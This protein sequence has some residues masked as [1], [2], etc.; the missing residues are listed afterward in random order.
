MG[1]EYSGIFSQQ[2]RRDILKTLAAVPVV[3]GLYSFDADASTVDSSDYPY[4]GQYG[5]NHLNQAYADSDDS[6]TDVDSVRSV[7]EDV[8]IDR[9]PVVGP[10]GN[11]AAAGEF[12]IIVAGN[13]DS[14][15][16]DA[17]GIVSTPLIHD[18]KVYYGDQLSDNIIDVESGEIIES[19]EGSN[20]VFRTVS[21]SGEFF[22]EKYKGL[23]KFDPDNLDTINSID[24]VSNPR[25]YGFIPRDDDFIAVFE[26]GVGK[27]DYEGDRLAGRA[28][29]SYNTNISGTDDVVVAIRN[30]DDILE[31]LDPETDDMAE[32]ASLENSVFTQFEAPCAI[33]GNS[34]Y[35]VN[36]DG[37]A[38][39]T[40]Y[41]DTE[42]EL[43]FDWKT[44]LDGD[45]RNTVVWGEVAIVS[46]TE[47]VVGLDTESGDEI[48]STSDANGFVSMPHDT[49][50]Y[51]G[52][53][54]TLYELTAELGDRAANSGLNEY[55]NDG[56]V[57]TSQ[58]LAGI[59]DWR[60]GALD[61]PK[62]LALINY[63]RSGET[64][65]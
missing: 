47:Q 11:V 5:G 63:W 44:E 62:L 10:N 21:S 41:D 35:N 32:K 60:S 8:D 53:E 37:V 38:F 24:I 3:G 16:L 30:G 43:K 54:N 22:R 40:S 19:N 48:W 46:T 17:D 36:R 6:P 20:R 15:V 31:V 23:E 55:T 25:P 61:T 13:G 7:E 18:G 64:I 9:I 57:G 26:Q 14:E 56:T 52:G 65:K 51:V 2:N 4:P 34:F 28:N 29:R 33:F 1:D 27:W 42:E 59:E 50:L 45:G 58:L 49:E 12:N 39:G